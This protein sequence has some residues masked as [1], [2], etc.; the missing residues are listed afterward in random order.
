MRPPE[1]E[2]QSFEAD[3]DILAGQV[4]KNSSDNAVSPSD[5]DAEECYGVATQ[6]VS[7]GDMVQVNGSGVRTIFV[8]GDGV[9]V[10]TDGTPVPLTSHGGT[11]DDG[12][13][14]VASTDGDFIIGYTYESGSEGDVVEGVVDRGYY[15]G[16]A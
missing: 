13:V 9:D 3:A 16:G 2:A 12:T 7:S 1:G 8:L 10:G 6:S 11:G 5:T 14:A 15:N 4:V